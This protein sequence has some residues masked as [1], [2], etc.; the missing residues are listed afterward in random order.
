MQSYSYLF[1]EVCSLLIYL[2]LIC[3]KAKE[4]LLNLQEVLQNAKEI[5][6]VRSLLSVQTMRI[7]EG[8]KKE[9][10]RD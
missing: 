10:L 1:R 3:L 4:Y 9:S 7:S 2:F 8:K 5:R 6:G